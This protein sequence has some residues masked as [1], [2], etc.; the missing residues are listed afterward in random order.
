[1]AA[2]RK[3]SEADRQALKDMWRERR[4][5]IAAI[6]KDYPT[7]QE[8]ADELGVKVVTVD[9]ILGEI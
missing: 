4:E 5:R 6:E 2:P 7:R 3:V 8:I 1:M 9:K